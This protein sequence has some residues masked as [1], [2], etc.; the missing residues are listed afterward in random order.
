MTPGPTGASPP[1][2]VSLAHLATQD[3]GTAL[4]ALASRPEGLTSAD[5]EERLARVGPNEIRAERRTLGGIV[6]GQLWSGIN[7]LLILAGILTFAVGSSTDGAIILV[8][9]LLNVGLSVLQ[10]YRAERALETLRALLPV[11][12]RVWRDGIE[13]EHPARDLVPGDVI[14]IKVG[15][16]IPADVR[17]LDA[18]GLEVNQAALTGESLSQTKDPAPVPAGPPSSWSDV[19][20]AGTTV[21]SGHGRGVVAATGER[22][23]FGETAALVRDIRATSDFQMNLSRFGGFL[24]RFGVV[25]AVAVFVSNALLGRGL[26]VSL[27]L[28]L[29]LMLGIVPEA[30]PAVTATALA[31]GAARLARKK[32]LVRR[33][34]AVEDLSVVDTLASDKT[35]TITQNRTTL[36]DVRTRTT[37]EEVLEAAVL[38]SSY[39]RRNENIVDDALIAA[40]E[41]RGLPLVD[42]ALVARR[43]LAPFSSE[44]KC[45]WTL[46]EGPAGRKVI[47]KGAA[48]VVLRNCRTVR[49]P[50]GDVD[51]GP[52]ARSVA[53]EIAGLQE[54]GGR[55][56]A[57]GERALAAG[58]PADANGDATLSL[59]GLLALSDPPRPGAAAA[60]ARAEALHVR[61]KIVTGDAVRRATALAAQ[62]GIPVSPETVVPA[63]ALQGPEV[64]EIAERGRI[65][66]AMVPADKYRLVRALQ[67]RGDHVAVTGDG[68]NDAPALRAADVGIALA[69]GSD[70]AKGAADLVL[71]EDD[72]AVIVEGIAEGRRL[73]TNINRYLLYT[74]VSNFAN[75]VVVAIASLFLPFLPLLPTQVLVLNV[76]ADLPMLAIV[77]DQVA[78][79]DLATPR[80]WDVRR[81]V[82]ITLYLGVLNAL[83]AFGLLRIVSG[84]PVPVIY[85]S[86]FLL[87]GTTALLILVVVR[88]PGPFWRAPP[89]SLPLGLAVAAGLAVTLFLINVPVAR[90]LFH[91]GPL[92]WAAQGGILVYSLGYVMAA[93]LFKR[94][95]LRASRPA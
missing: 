10:E 79:E 3:S 89:L 11:T 66:G 69:G 23:Q 82:E 73:F 53:G 65:F 9:V 24:L 32:V 36:T 4:R 44:R 38:C 64:G 46:V 48:D 12:V 8:L 37:P 30:L 84:Q 62:I 17:L 63:D 19:L 18:A 15:N 78:A 5:A 7:L 6:W 39:P 68:V 58:D 14:E 34:A 76:L 56:I 54:R 25:L 21:V 27:T 77:T 16:L 91:F 50:G 55:V 1:Q 57:V 67:A 59:L 28:S 92:S 45:A 72:L 86:W 31:V 75:V 70:A 85:S 35:G 40:A 94:A 87:L 71:L 20:F 74:M 81:L 13:S 2:I 29:A 42:L 26:V 93:D 49:T 80:R 47:V 51:L 83:F 22:T 52:L 43:T 90:S 61:V 60:L 33:L 88:T 41:A 95:F